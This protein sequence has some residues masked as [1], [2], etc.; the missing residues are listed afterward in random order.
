[1]GKLPRH[2]PHREFPDARRIIVECELERCVYCG[3]PLVFSKTWHMR[4]TVQTLNGTVFVAGRSKQCNNPDCYHFGKHYH[5]GGILRISLPYCTYGLDVMAF[6]GWQHE[7]EHKPFVEIRR[8]LNEYGV[9]VSERHVGRLYRQFVALLSGLDERRERQLQE[10]AAQ[11]DGVIWGLNGLQPPEYEGTLYVL[12]EVWS[13][14]PVSAVQMLH[15][16]AETL[17]DWLRRFRELPFAVLATLSDGE[18]AVVEALQL[19]WPEVQVFTPAPPGSDAPPCPP[20]RNT[21]R[22]RCTSDISR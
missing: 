9:E 12:Y 19:C 15:P 21:R 7:H 16:T 11:H 2:R 22:T 20:R 3:A 18:E 4:K 14:T 13:G 6:I 1:M 8:Q 5:A 17:A 10:S